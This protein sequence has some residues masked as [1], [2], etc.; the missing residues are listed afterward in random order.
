MCK[1]G[2]RT[3]WKK[4]DCQ[5]EVKIL[6]N[7]SSSHRVAYMVLKFLCDKLFSGFIEDGSV[8]TTYRIKTVVL[9]HIQNCETCE[10]VTSTQFGIK[11]FPSVSVTFHQ[12]IQLASSKYKGK[13]TITK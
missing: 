1:Q 11:F 12:W 7:S 9:H 2:H 13:A 3:C 10:V 4:S 6:K 5:I 8:P